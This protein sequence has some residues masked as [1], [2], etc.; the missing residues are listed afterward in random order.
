MFVY[1][2]IHVTTII[3]KREHELREQKG[4][5]GCGRSWKEIQ[6]YYNLKK[7]KNGSGQKEC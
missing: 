2:Y 4:R 3:V 5:R 6:L 1:T 7:I